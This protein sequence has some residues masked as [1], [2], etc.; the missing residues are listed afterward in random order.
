MRVSRFIHAYCGYNLSHMG[1]RLRHHDL[2]SRSL[3][4]HHKKV[5]LYC[6][7]PWRPIGL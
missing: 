2:V 6:N 1:T 7:R 4:H 3:R 5:K